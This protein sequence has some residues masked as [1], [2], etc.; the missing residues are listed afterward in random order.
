MRLEDD[1][2]RRFLRWWAAL[3]LV[4]LLLAA[5]RS[6]GYYHPDEQFQTLE[7]AGAK[8]GLTTPDQLPWEY[9]YRMRSWLQPALYVVAIGTLRRLSSNP[10]VWATALRVLSALYAWGATVALSRCCAAWLEDRGSRRAAIRLVCS[11]CLLPFALVRTSGESLATS[12]FFLGLA[13]FELAGSRERTIGRALLTGAFFGLA[14]EFRFAAGLMVA[15]WLA[16]AAFVRRRPRREILSVGLA[17]AAVVAATALVDRWGYG[18]WSLPP[19][20]YLIENLRAGRAAARFGS[21]P[22]WGYLTLVLGLP[23]GPAT[24]LAAAATAVAWMRHPRHVLTWCGV[25]MLL[26]H[27]LIAHKELRFLFPLLPAAAVSFGLAIAPGSD[28]LERLARLLRGESTLRLRRVLSGANAVALAVLCLVPVGPRAGLQRFVYEELPREPELLVLGPETPYGPEGLVGRFYLPPD[29]TLRILG[30]P[31]L[32][33]KL[34]DA[35]RPSNVVVPEEVSAELV[36]AGRC[37]ELYRSV[38]PLLDGV[39]GIRALDRWRV[40]RCEAARA[41]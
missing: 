29:T 6:A 13:L 38:P 30:A 41:S 12:S 37:R 3:S 22:V 8:L 9:A 16:W 7:F 40:L 33:R 1:G 4:C 31:E 17:A 34:R 32:E 15:G 14:F 35:R 27:S 11:F 2:D 25:P 19:W 24:S 39:P 36:A 23:F 10:F 5:W 18:A 26:V 28:R 20:N 21:L